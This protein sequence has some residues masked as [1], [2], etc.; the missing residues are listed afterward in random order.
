MTGRDQIAMVVMRLATLGGPKATW[1][2]VVHVCSFQVSFPNEGL[3]YSK[4]VQWVFC[5]IDHV[6]SWLFGGHWYSLYLQFKA[7]LTVPF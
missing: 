1:H 2:D 5:W 7:L 4:T 3:G 6:V